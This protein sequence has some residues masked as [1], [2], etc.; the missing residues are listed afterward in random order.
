M[1]AL[2]GAALAAV[3]LW[4]AAWL[5]VRNQRLDREL[6]RYMRS[7]P[8][9]ASQPELDGAEAWFRECQQA[10]GPLQIL[11]EW[12]VFVRAA[13]MLAQDAAGAA[14]SRRARWSEHLARARREA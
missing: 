14:W 1:T 5:I 9:D 4:L 13:G 11:V 3:F 12:L 7:L 2:S 10:V 6:L 8:A